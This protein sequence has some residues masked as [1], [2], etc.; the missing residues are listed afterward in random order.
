MWRKSVILGISAFY[1]DSAAALV[2]DGKIVAAA[3]EERFTRKK[4]DADFP[5]NAIQFVLNYALADP[6]QVDTVVFYEKPLLKFERLLETYHHFAPKGLSSWL[7]A[8]PLWM[9]EKL[10][11]R[12]LIKKNLRK[13][14]LNDY[15]LL[16]SEHHLSHAASAFYP[17][18]FKESAIL[19]I[20]GVGEWSTTTIG[21]GNQNKITI[22]KEL[23][24][25]HSLGLLYSAVTY[26]CGFEVND[27]EYKLMGL[28]PYGDEHSSQYH[29]FRQKILNNLVD[30]RNDGSLLLN[31]D[32]FEFATGL[33]MTNNQRWTE[34]FGLAPRIAEGELK[35]DYMNLAL[36]FQRVTEEII[37]KLAQTARSLTGS[38]HLVMAG[39]VALNS[40]AN[41][42]LAASGIFDDIW[43]QPAP[44][45]PEVH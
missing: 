10:F 40:V 17:S 41:G 3:Q 23:H 20:D 6:G 13:L 31:M 1:H 19:T 32:Y 5:L 26:Y 33:R 30:V 38:S 4:H 24:F 35:F 11:I 34:L 15:E 25:P 44:L 9:K 29:R 7:K 45:M 16:F 8:M 43:I 39:G 36:A 18:P 28:A 21:Y 14:H 27:G 37:F 12:N 42:K 22:L 2:I